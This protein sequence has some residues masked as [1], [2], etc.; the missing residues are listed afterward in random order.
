MQVPLERDATTK[1]F[2]PSVLL[3]YSLDL[4]FSLSIP[5]LC[6]TINNASSGWILRRHN[7]EFTIS[8]SRR[9]HP[10]F[11]K[12]VDR[13]A[14]CNLG[15]HLRFWIIGCHNPPVVSAAAVPA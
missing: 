5:D 2:S 12:A 13:T 15:C 11:R 3:N 4:S 6:F 1:L 7:Y 9:T 10:V 8:L 14:F